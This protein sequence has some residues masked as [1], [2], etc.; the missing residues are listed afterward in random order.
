[1]KSLNAKTDISIFIHLRY[2]RLKLLK[3]KENNK[4]IWDIFH[5]TC[6]FKNM[7]C[8]VTSE[9]S[10]KRFYFV[11]HVYDDGLTL[12]TSKLVYICFC[13]QTL[14]VLIKAHIIVV[15]RHFQMWHKFWQICGTKKKLNSAW[16]KIYWPK[17]CNATV[18]SCSY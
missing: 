8:Y 2:L 12:K 16:K 4:K 11:L 7:P 14:Q 10:L 13:I 5:H 6:N 3:N 15:Q 17:Y 1:M 18:S 9:V